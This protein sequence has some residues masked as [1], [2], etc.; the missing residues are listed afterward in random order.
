MQNLSLLDKL[1]HGACDFLN[2]NIWIDAMLIVEVNVICSETFQRAFQTI[3]DMLRTAVPAKLRADNNLFS[4]G[5][6]GFSQQ[7]FIRVGTVTLC[8]SAFSRLA[9]KT[10]RNP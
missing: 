9:S 5:L 8:G 1:L 6:E 7:F 2:R 3:A 4:V 10:A